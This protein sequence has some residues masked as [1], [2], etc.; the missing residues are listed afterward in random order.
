[1][2]DEILGNL[3]KF[4]SRAEMTESVNMSAFVSRLLLG[5]GP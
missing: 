1:M 5:F 4:T 2:S 3:A